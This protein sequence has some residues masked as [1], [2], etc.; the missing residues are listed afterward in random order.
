MRPCRLHFGGTGGISAQRL[1]V[2][3]E[4]YGLSSGRPQSEAGRL[5]R[6]SQPKVI[7]GINRIIII[8]IVLWRLIALGLAGGHNH[9][10][11]N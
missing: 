2:K 3:M 9:T 4:A 8:R 11:C 6:V 7:T 5:R 10:G 1:T